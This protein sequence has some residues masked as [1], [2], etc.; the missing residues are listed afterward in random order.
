M[1]YTTVEFFPS[2]R[3]NKRMM[4][5]FMD[6]GRKSDIVHFGS[7]GSSTY[8][9]H[10][11]DKKKE[12]YIKRHSKL[13]ENWDNPRSAGALSRWI[14]WNE[15]TLEASINSYKKMFGYG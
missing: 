13:N 6:R 10:G 9:D 2:N 8:I 4:A 7:K 15:P 5:Q 12:N 14:L 3:K 1:I 11:D